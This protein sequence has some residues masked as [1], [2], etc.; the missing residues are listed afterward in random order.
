MQLGLSLVVAI[1][2][3]KIDNTGCNESFYKL[4]QGASILLTI[5]SIIANIYFKYKDGFSK[6]CFFILLALC[7]ILAAIVLIV[8]FA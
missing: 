7:I 3:M 5:L 6:S 1:E 2:V 4:V 8:A